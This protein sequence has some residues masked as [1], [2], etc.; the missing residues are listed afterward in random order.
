VGKPCAAAGSGQYRELQSDATRHE[1]QCARRGDPGHRPGY[2]RPEWRGTRGVTTYASLAILAL[3]LGAHAVFRLGARIRTRWAGETPPFRAGVFAE[4]SKLG[5]MWGLAALV[6][7]LLSSA[8]LDESEGMAA[9][10]V[11]L[12]LV[13]GF[14]FAAYGFTLGLGTLLGFFRFRPD[15]A[16]APWGRQALATGLAVGG[17]SALVC[18]LPFVALG[19]EPPR[20]WPLLGSLSALCLLSV[21]IAAGVFRRARTPAG[22]AGPAE[23]GVPGACRGDGV[24]G[25]GVVGVLWALAVPMSAL[26]LYDW[27]RP[28]ALAPVNPALEPWGLP[29]WLVPAALAAGTWWGGELARR[30]TL[31]PFLLAVAIQALHVVGGLATG[32]DLVAGGASFVLLVFAWPLWYLG[33]D[34][35]RKAFRS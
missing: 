18:S 20:A 33:R 26:R 5:C 15:R 1:P 23:P 22:G 35:L 14:G 19:A 2:G 3:I 11:V 21:A 12:M 29:F 25:V 28:G 32:D 17:V 8:A 9:A 34:E 7:V 27:L 24:Q 6:A 30:C 4:A 13:A 16:D 10:A 31:A